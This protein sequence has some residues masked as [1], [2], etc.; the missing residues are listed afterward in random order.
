MLTAAPE[1][2]RCAKACAFLLVNHEVVQD[3]EPE[4]LI[5]R[6]AQGDSA[7]LVVLYD[8]F[9]SLLF[10]LALRIVG[11][12]TEAEDVI[13][14]VFVRAWREAPS[15]DRKKG[16]AAAW[17]STLTRNRAIDLVRARKRRA[18]HDELRSAEN[19]THIETRSPEV[20]ASVSE[21]TRAVQAA[22][23]L[24]TPEQ[25]NALEL[26]YFGGLSHSEIAE[27]LNQPLGTIKTRLL[28]AARKLREV[29]AA[30]DESTRNSHSQN[31]EKVMEEA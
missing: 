24:L 28:A 27:A 5:E 1:G 26:A 31:A 19:E 11:H 10:A 21:R 3:L 17:L 4:L 30:H 25:K 6:A 14:E 29:L 16:S 20:E 22:I 9:G 18:T 7:A 23:Q 2:T 8:R 15:F 13:Q 12:R